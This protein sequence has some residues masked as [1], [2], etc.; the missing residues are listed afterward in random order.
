MPK[1]YWVCFVLGDGCVEA[2]CVDAPVARWY[3]EPPGT[4]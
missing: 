1:Y 3:R 2:P 4:I